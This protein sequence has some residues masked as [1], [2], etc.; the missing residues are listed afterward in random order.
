[1]QSGIERLRVRSVGQEAVAEIGLGRRADADRRARRGEEVELGTVCVRRVH[2]RRALRQAAGAGEELDRAAA[3]LG[4]ALLDLLAAARRRGRGAGA[5]RRPRSA[6]ISSSQSAGHARTEWGATPTSIP[7]ARSISTWS[8]NSPTELLPE[9]GETATRVGDV[10]EHELD[11]R[12][13]RR[14]GRS[15]GL[16]DAEVVELADSRVSGREHLAIRQLVLAAD[17]VRRL[18]L[19]LR[20]AWSRATPRSRRRPRSR[21][22]PLERVAVRVHEARES[23]RARHEA[24][25]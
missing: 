11:A 16:G 1:M 15:K 4:E 14:L 12:R 21:A 8:R 24:R 25:R 9:A 6:P 7:A 19:R 2:D 23:E 5:P 17:E 3:V 10:K 18:A 20:R 13:G 22:V